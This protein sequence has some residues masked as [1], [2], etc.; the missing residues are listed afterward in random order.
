MEQTHRESATA[1]E[2]V[3]EASRAPAAAAQ[4][5]RMLQTTVGPALLRRALAGMQDEQRAGVVRSIQR[6]AGNRAVLRL[7][8]RAAVED[9]EEDFELCF[10][11]SAGQVGI[12]ALF[13]ED[14]AGLKPDDQQAVL[15]WM[16]ETD[17]LYGARIGDMRRRV[18]EEE[19]KRGDA[20]AGAG[21]RGLGLGKGSASGHTPDMAGGA[22]FDAPQI[23]LPSRINSSIGGQW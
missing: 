13:L 5:A 21:R 11:G 22:A 4:A 3:I 7:L 23:G 18:S 17:Q 10:H 14:W 9:P 12:G 6:S 19:R 16:R 1:P 20:V 8:Q 15:F 2:A